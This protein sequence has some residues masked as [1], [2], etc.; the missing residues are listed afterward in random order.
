[1]FKNE[2]IYGI[3]FLI[4]KSSIMTKKYIQTNIFGNLFF[5]DSTAVQDVKVRLV[6]SIK[7]KLAQTLF[8]LFLSISFSTIS[9]L[10]LFTYGIKYAVTAVPGFDPLCARLSPSRYLI[11]S[12]ACRMSN[13]PWGMVVVRVSWPGHPT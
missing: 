2:Y 5:Q 8:P 6:H 1:L 11:C 10:S 3:V 7:L 4:K 9:F 13:G 12:W